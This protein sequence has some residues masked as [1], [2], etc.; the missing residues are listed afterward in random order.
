MSRLRVVALF[1]GIAAVPVISLVRESSRR[2]W[3]AQVPL[4]KAAM[5]V[6]LATALFSALAL[7]VM[8]FMPSAAA[9]AVVGWFALA[10]FH[11]SA[12][13][14][15]LY[16]M[17]WV[18][19]WHWVLLLLAVVA[20]AWWIGTRFN[21]AARVL[22]T[23]VPLLVASQVVLLA[24][25]IP[26]WNE[27]TPRPMTAR[28]VTLGTPPSIWVIVLDSHASPR[29]LREIHG[30]DLI[31]ETRDL[32]A[33]GFRV[34]DDARSNYTHTVA[35]VPSLLS[36]QTWDSATIEA[37]YAELL[38]GVHGGGSLVATLK[39]AGHTIRMVPTNWSRSRCGD[40]VDVC[41][42][43]PSYDEQWYFLLRSTPLPDIVPGLIPHPWPV[44]GLRTLGKISAL[45]DDGSPHFT[46][47]HSLASHP[48]TIIG[49]D[50]EA[51]SS[52]DGD[53]ESQ[54]RCT[55][56][57]LQEALGS[58]DLA[59]DVVVVTADHGYDVGNVSSPP[60]AWSDATTRD[61]FSAFT[62]ISTPDGCESSMPEQLS[63][64]QILPMI[65]NCHGA[66]VPVPDH[67]FA[68]VNQRAYGPIFSTDLS[69]DGWSVYEPF[70]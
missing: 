22:T 47:V 5:M 7:L 23:F 54:L 50:C 21:S 35:A 15:A 41:V 33:V 10:F 60:D 14:A 12:V 69:W 8:R 63:A 53:L 42:G 37:N 44:G 65:L 17:G 4:T 30:I 28:E 29:V 16:R 68:K 40:L 25:E 56:D 36:G 49:T 13:R 3:T 64:A 18:E 11:A 43:A 62:A 51:V 32:E 66:D 52:F 55:H 48:P 31:E 57:A 61:R 34:W 1:A 6:I 46:F 27:P 38:A 19:P 59:T 45:E 2:V 58:I 24:I 67:R 20:A 26:R 9:V 70:R 39:D